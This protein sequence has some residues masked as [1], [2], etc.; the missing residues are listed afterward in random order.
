MGLC[1]GS[2]SPSIAQSHG[3]APVRLW[4]RRGACTATVAP[5]VPRGSEKSWPSRS[6]SAESLGCSGY[7]ITT[8]WVLDMVKATPTGSCSRF[9]VAS[10]Q[11]TVFIYSFGNV[12][13]AQTA[14]AHSAPS[15]R[16]A[17]CQGSLQPLLRLSD[18]D[19][20]WARKKTARMHHKF[21][22]KVR[23]K[24]ERFLGFI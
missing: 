17:R 1:G 6:P 3:L 22:D 23:V 9:A 18:A 4:H 20:L 10:V 8:L 14:D 21:E 7:R 16:A 12:P 13:S 24:A 5:L 11:R 2:V 15:R 19:G